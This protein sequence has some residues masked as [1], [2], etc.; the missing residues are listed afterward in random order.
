MDG[1]KGSVFE[2][3]YNEPAISQNKYL[4][5]SAVTRGGR[6]YAT[7]YVTR[8]ARDWKKRFESYLKREIKKQKWDM[9]QTRSGIWAVDF[10][11]WRSRINQDTHNMFKCTLDSMKD[12][13]LFVDDANIIVRTVDVFD[14]DKKNPRFLF[15]LY[16]HKD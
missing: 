9:E 10:T 6:A 5:P 13:G 15:K 4:A 12:A 16:K 11:F 3:Q 7:M 1:N 8:E 14:N 2:M